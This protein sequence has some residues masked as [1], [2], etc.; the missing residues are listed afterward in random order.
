L[1]NGE[2][3]VRW[4]ADGSHLFL[5]QPEGDTIKISRLDLAIW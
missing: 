4:S 2:A 1:Q 5:R 3:V